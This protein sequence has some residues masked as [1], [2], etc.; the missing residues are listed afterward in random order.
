MSDMSGSAKRP[1][2]AMSGN[3]K[4]P[5]SVTSGNDARS[6]NDWNGKMKTTTIARSGEPL[7]PFSHLGDYC[8]EPKTSR[9][10]PALTRAVVNSLR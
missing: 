1:M 9:Q 8:F 6:E 7:W 10:R 2:S 3:V 5:M 4:R